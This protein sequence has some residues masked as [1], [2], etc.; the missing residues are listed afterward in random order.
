MATLIKGIRCPDARR[1]FD[2]DVC[3]LNDKICLLEGGEKCPYYEQ[4]L[5]EAENKCPN[6]GT[7]LEHFSG[8]ERIP[9]YLYCPKCMD[10]AYGLDGEVLFRLE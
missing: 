4:F 2:L 9:E 10:K 8:L 3:N 1:A 6:C 7:E 5:V